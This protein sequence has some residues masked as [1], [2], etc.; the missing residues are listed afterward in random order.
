MPLNVVGRVVVVV[1]LVTVMPGA[2]MLII[3]ECNV[4]KRY[5]FYRVSSRVQTHCSVLNINGLLV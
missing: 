2:N 5:V 3:P 1:V 4:T